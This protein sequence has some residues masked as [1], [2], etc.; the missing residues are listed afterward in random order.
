MKNWERNY[1]A[2]RAVRARSARSL[3]HSPQQPACHVELLAFQSDTQSSLCPSSVVIN[4]GD[5]VLPAWRCES[6]RQTTLVDGVV[7]RSACR[8]FGEPHLLSFDGDE[9]WRM[10]QF[11]EAVAFDQSFYGQMRPSDCWQ[12]L[13][14]IRIWVRTYHLEPRRHQR[15]RLLQTASACLERLRW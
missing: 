11:Y 3:P 4:D 9:R 5:V 10:R 12:I 13:V 14:R 7:P 2:R 1:L 15:A 8:G 6:C